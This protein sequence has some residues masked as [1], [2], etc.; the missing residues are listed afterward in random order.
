MNKN[1]S[2]LLNKTY[3]CWGTMTSRVS[4][5]FNAVAFTLLLLACQ[6]ETKLLSILN[7]QGADNFIQLLF[8]IEKY[9]L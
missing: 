1:S 7:L 6:K 9:N 8:I 4:R 5:I 2:A 3:L